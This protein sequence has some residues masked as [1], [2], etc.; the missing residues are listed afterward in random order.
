[1]L[2]PHI[3]PFCFAA[4]SIS[5]ATTVQSS[6]V[7]LS[8]NL[9]MKS[10]TLWLVGFVFASAILLW[11]FFKLGTET[12]E[13]FPVLQWWPCSSRYRGASAERCPGW[14]SYMFRGARMKGCWCSLGEVLTVMC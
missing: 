12:W 2:V 10:F 5:F 6:R 9:L 13:V 3:R 11:S 7:C 8:G 14:H 4:S 1:M